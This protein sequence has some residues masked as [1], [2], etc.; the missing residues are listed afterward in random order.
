MKHHSKAAIIAGFVAAA[1]L[2]ALVVG[3]LATGAAAFPPG[4][5]MPKVVV[6]SGAA[7]C[8]IESY[9]SY[10]WVTWRASSGNAIWVARSS[11]ASTTT[12]N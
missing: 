8:D 11:S 6:A 7:T 10:V 4:W 3:L 1:A 5:T 12:S 9:G 2:A